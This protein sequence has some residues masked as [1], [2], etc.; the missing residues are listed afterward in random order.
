[1]VQGRETGDGGRGEVSRQYPVDSERTAAIREERDEYENA[2][3]VEVEEEEPAFE[4]KLV[5]EEKEAEV[6]DYSLYK[7][8]G[9]EQMVLG[10]DREKHVS[11]VHGGKS[12]KFWRL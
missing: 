8:Q 7:C 12:Q 4:D 3:A 5:T 6:S 11:A 10:F 9:C 2:G 1:M